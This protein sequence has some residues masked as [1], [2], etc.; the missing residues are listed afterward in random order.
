MLYAS[1]GLFII[2]IIVLVVGYRKNDRNML[3]VAAIILF[4]SAALEDFVQGFEEG[5]MEDQREHSSI[6]HPNWLAD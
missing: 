3:V 4:T 2:G 5:L 1:L 6:Q